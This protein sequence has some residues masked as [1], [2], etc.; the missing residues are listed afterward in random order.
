MALA[1][2]YLVW[3]STYLAIRVAVETI[4]PFA[5]SSLRFLIAGT[6]LYTFL[7]WRGAPN[8]T[9]R[10]WIDNAIIGTLLIL[11]GNGLVG[12]A[13]QF[14]DSGI[15]ALLIGIGPLFIV[16]TE[17]AWPGG[18][19]PTV[20]TFGALLLGLGGVA[21][22]AAPWETPSEGGLHQIGV[23]VILAACAFWAIGAIYSRH[24]K[25]GASPFMSAALQMLC[26]CL[27]LTLVGLFSGDYT[28]F[29]ITGVSTRSWI[30][31]IYLILI[32]SLVGFSTFVW[33]MKNVPPAIVSTHAYINP[34]VAVFLGWWLLDEEVSLRTFAAT[35]IIIL[36]VAIITTQKNRL[37]RVVPPRQAVSA[38]KS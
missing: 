4:P 12:W 15:A 2:I 26:G 37:Q 21:W 30:A 22:L 31:L 9:A 25:N 28:R 6:M 35:A 20:I 13:E 10:Q 19:R 24:T 17:W 36:S 11:G 29:D 8:P 27:A 5:M 3:G 33:L 23:V 34:P 38:V 32:G 1:T 7:K 18:Q 14:I 16:L